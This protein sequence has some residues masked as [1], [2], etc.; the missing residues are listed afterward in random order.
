MFDVMIG[1][2]G[3][4][5]FEFGRKARFGPIR[6]GVGF[7]IGNVQDRSVRL[8]GFQALA[9]ETVPRTVDA[10]PVYR[11]LDVLRLDQIP[12]L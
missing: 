2:G 1:D 7:K 6:I 3:V 5:P 4:F 8:Q 11:T 9:G 10:V 12:P